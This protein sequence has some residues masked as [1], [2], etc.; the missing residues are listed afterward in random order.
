[1]S[2]ISGYAF[3]DASSSSSSLNWFSWGALWQRSMKNY[4]Y[5]RL[6]LCRCFIII[7]ILKLI[8]MRS[9]MTKV[10]ESMIII[11]GYAFAD[12]SAPGGQWGPLAEV[13]HHAYIDEKTTLM[14][15]WK[16]YVDEDGK[17][18]VASGKKFQN[19]WFQNKPTDGPLG[20]GRGAS[21]WMEMVNNASYKPPFKY[22]PQI[23]AQ[24]FA[25]KYLPRWMGIVNRSSRQTNTSKFCPKRSEPSHPTSPSVPST[26]PL[27]SPS[28]SGTTKRWEMFWETHYTW[29]TGIRISNMVIETF[30]TIL[31]V[32]LL[33]SQL[34]LSEPNKIKISDINC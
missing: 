33:F 3:A 6:R 34:L 13:V 26:S 11:S 21:R 10:H 23:I 17:D 19:I 22:M 30:I 9:F 2:I 29:V 14:R 31:M 16:K 18:H 5:L 28:N 15:S 25:P 12:A 1:M 27:L 32:R 7:V 20:G 8:M 24:L 4:Y